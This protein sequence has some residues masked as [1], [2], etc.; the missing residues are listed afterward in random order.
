MRTGNSK[1]DTEGLVALATAGL[2][3]AS[4]P[5]LLLVLKSD[6]DFFLFLINLIVPEQYNLN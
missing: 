3:L 6:V 1:I 4:I 2:L 5:F